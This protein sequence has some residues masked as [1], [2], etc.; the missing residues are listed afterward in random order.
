[1]PPAGIL[2]PVVMLLHMPHDFD[3]GSDVVAHV[4]VLYL[5]RVLCLRMFCPRPSG[6]STSYGVST[7]TRIRTTRWRWRRQ[8]LQRQRT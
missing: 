6:V 3:L 7:G 8:N 5:L 2:R 1:M 4:V